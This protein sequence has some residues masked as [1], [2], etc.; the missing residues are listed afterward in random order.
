M[1]CAC[2]DCGEKYKVDI[3][4]PDYLWE[5][6]KPSGTAIGGGMLCGKCIFKRM[7][8]WDE[9]NAFELKEIT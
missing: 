6:I 9:Y 4:I 5:K 1:A 7:E 3:I 2:Q 8:K